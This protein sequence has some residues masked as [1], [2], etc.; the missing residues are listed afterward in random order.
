M[1]LI[2]PF[3]LLRQQLQHGEATIRP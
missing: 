3:K 1:E 2:G